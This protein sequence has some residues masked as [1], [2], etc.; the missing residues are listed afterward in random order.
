MIFQAP[1]WKQKI[2]SHVYSCYSVIQSNDQP[3]SPS[4]YP[5]PSVNCVHGV[6][7]CFDL[8][9][10]KVEVFLLLHSQLYEKIVGICQFC[11][12]TL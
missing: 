11:F 2:Y 9:D 12:S 3:P 4:P 6:P 10:G 8:K 1:L 5:A 7:N